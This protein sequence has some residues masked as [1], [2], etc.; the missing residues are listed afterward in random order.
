MQIA[1]KAAE[2]RTKDASQ[3]IERAVRQTLPEATVSVRQLFP[4]ASTGNRAR[5]FVVE[6]PD[7][8]PPTDVAQVVAA[9]NGHAAIE[10]ASIPSPKTGAED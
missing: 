10:Y 6:V 3:A 4:D 7:H 2:G 1:V 5:L 9:L 8:L